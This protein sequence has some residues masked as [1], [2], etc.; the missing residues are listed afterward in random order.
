MRAPTQL[1]AR[2]A[3]LLTAW[4]LVGPPTAAER[5]AVSR[6]L[7]DFHQ[8]LTRDEKLESDA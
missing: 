4:Q 7:W 3:A 8:G 5:D 6:W 2:A 1:E